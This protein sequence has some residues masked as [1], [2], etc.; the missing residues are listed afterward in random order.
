MQSADVLTEPPQTDH[1]KTFHSFIIY[2][3]EKVWLSLC[4]EAHLHLCNT[5]WSIGCGDAFLSIRILWLVI[6]TLEP[7]HYLLHQ[8]SFLCA[9][10]IACPWHSLGFKSLFNPEILRHTCCGEHTN[11]YWERQITPCVSQGTNPSW[12]LSV[13][14]FP[15]F[16]KQLLLYVLTREMWLLTGAQVWRRRHRQWSHVT[17]HLW[18]QSRTWGFTHKHTVRNHYVFFYKTTDLKLID[19]TEK[20]KN[21]CVFS[22]ELAFS[23]YIGVG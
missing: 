1:L 18:D 22:R 5:L 21:E 6:H 4:Y 23:V 10:F 3:G 12:H 11:A 20:R 17:P 7:H 19:G 8:E 15:T 13:P 2:K 14:I 16:S 9:F